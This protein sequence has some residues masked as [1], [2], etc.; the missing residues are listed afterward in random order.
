MSRETM[1]TLLNIG[2]FG[3]LVVLAAYGCWG[4]FCC[5]MVGNLIGAILVQLRN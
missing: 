2:Q 1:E 3:A 4:E 5:L